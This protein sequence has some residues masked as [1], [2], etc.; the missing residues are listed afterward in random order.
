[1]RGRPRRAPTAI[2]I[3]IALGLLTA[4]GAVWAVVSSDDENADA[5]VIRAT[6]SGISVPGSQPSP[7]MVQARVPLPEITATRDGREFVLHY[8]F[9]VFPDDPFERP[10]VLIVSADSAGSRVPPVT[11]RHRIGGPEGT[12]RQPLGIGDPPFE[13]L[14]SVLTVADVRSSG[15]ARTPLR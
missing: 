14:V 4:A 5:D 1:M 11:L 12:V 3:A 15:I 9:A 6:R 7:D 10:A 2:V 13:I 8:R